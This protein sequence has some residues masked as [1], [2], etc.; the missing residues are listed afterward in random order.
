M[1]TL[2]QQ[3]YK[4][5]ISFINYQKQFATIGYLHNNKE[6]TVNFR[7][8]MGKGKKAQQFRLGDGVDF[9]LKLSDRGDKM[10]A[11]NVRFTHNTSIDLLIQKAA[12]ENRFAGYLKVVEDK[13]FVKELETYILFPLRLSS[14]EVPPV[15]TAVNVAINFK[16]IDL[17][18]QNSIQAELF[19][20]NYIPEYRKAL[21]HFNNEIDIEA[22]VS[23]VSPHAV[24]LD[25]FGEKMKAKLNVSEAGEVKEG[26]TI[27]VLITYL[28]PYRIV[29]K[30]ISE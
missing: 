18:K 12:I 5:K 16:L 26:D 30:K 4:G 1:S 7:T 15:E 8:D 3:V 13:Y 9:Q 24:Y 10:A 25:L 17:D 29:V 27:R 19:S 21:Q 28:N 14:W 2:D 20:H 23:R 22:K 11:Y 6:K